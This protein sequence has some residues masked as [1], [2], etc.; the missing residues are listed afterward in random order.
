MISSIARLI[1]KIDIGK[2]LAV[3]VMH[4]ETVWALPQQTKAAGSGA[5]A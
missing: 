3:G 1:L 2:L 4:D 5:P